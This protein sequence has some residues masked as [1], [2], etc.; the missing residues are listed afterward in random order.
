[1]SYGVAESGDLGT[2]FGSGTEGVPT[3]DEDLEGEIKPKGLQCSEKRQQVKDGD[4]FSVTIEEGD[5]FMAVKPW[6]GVVN[7]SVPD[8]FRPSKR[9]GEAPD[10]TLEL[11][12]VHG[13]RCHD[14]R[15][16]LKYTASGKLAY[17]SAGVG[18]VMDT[19]NNT[20][21]HFMEHSDDIHCIAMHPNGRFCATGQIGPKPRICV[22]DN[23]TMECRVLVTQPLTKGVKHM[24]F[25]NDGKY[26]V[27]SAMDDDQMVA[28]FEWEKPPAKP[29]KPVAPVAHGKSTRAKILSIGFNPA[30]NQIVATCVKEVSFMSFANG[31]IKAQKGTGWGA[32]A[33]ESVLAQAFVGDQLFTGSYTGDIIQWNGR[34]L[35]KRT[36]AHEGRINCMHS[37]GQRLVTG[38]HDGLVNIW[39][40]SGAL[41]KQLTVDLK[42]P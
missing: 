27:A 25:S 16:N 41:Q 12:Y 3:I 21:K 11:E 5:Q 32:K 19:R 34:N 7:N 29:G 23:E 26:L 33:A 24:A 38:G 13:F 18:V 20:Q 1:M 2:D 10:A 37:Q 42:I 8:G 30:G 15:N 40:V 28:V 6:V 4:E 35:A 39:Q 17:I 36:K 14:C 31:V 22:W 9:D